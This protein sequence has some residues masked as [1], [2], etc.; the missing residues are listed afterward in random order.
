[1]NC[2]MKHLKTM[3]AVFVISATSLVPF[4]SFA[5]EDNFNVEAK[6]AIVID[7]D[8]GKIF[9]EKNSDQPLPIASMTK[10]ITLYIAME[11][12]E[13]GKLNWDDQIEISDHLLKISHNME[14][15]NI[16]FTKGQTYSV[17]DLFN[18]SA[19]V[20]ANA[21]VT[22][23]AEKIAGTE[24]DFVDLMRKKMAIWG[25]TD[26]Y[27]ISTS[28]INNDSAEGRIYPGSKADE[29]NLASAKDMAIVARHLINDFPEILDITKEP[30]VV[31]AKDTDDETIMESTNWML[32]EKPNYRPGVDGLKTG[33]T[34]LAGECFAGTFTDGNTR[35]I[36]IIM[37]SDNSEEQ[38]DARFI[39]TDKLI[40][41]VYNNWEF[42]VLYKKGDVA[43]SQHVKGGID[44]LTPVLLDEEISSWVRIGT[45]KSTYPI[46]INKTELSAG[47]DKGK[48]AGTAR[49][50]LN[51][52]ELGSVESQNNEK[53]FKLITKEPVE[54]A[55][56]Y[57]L[58]GRSIS[59]FFKKLI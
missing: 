9:Y 37:N 39:E 1:M 50:D 40:D 5:E 36:T 14:L 51:D 42:K 46:E 29:E 35:I 2:L 8:T 38:E 34:D 53:N 27:L 10:L 25:I 6:A 49:V 7:A 54:K 58:V 13:N 33:T 30:Q 32:P 16:A 59:D 24:K 56:W 48:F 3:I 17:R 20:S 19:I 28:G 15:S 11:A 31:F 55:P 26:S 44:R 41:Y 4:I 12:I 21:A 45:D 43:G 47:L 23:L 22:A 18:A 52:N 57:T